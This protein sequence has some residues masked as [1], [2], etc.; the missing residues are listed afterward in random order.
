MNSVDDKLKHVGHQ[1][2]DAWLPR[3]TNTHQDHVIAHVLG[4][5]VL[6]Y[7]VFD[8][9]LYLILDIGFIW[10][11]YVDGEMAL[12]PH[13]V[14]VSELEFDTAVRNEIRTDIDLLLRG[15][16]PE[17][18]L[19][20]ITPMPLH[21]DASPGEIREVAFFECTD[22]R[23]F[24]LNCDNTKLVVETEITNAEIQVYVSE[25]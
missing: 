1:D 24:E 10:T 3:D 14:A 18:K 7:F 17:E 2:A 12:L 8:E 11:I 16:S 9:A 13:P 25:Q 23:R 19:L 15:K 4:T 21:T 6:G 22:R 5:T 20:R